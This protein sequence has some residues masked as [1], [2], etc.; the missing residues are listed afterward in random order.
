MR[1][2]RRHAPDAVELLRLAIDCLPVATREAMLEG[3]RANERVIAGAYVDDRGGVCPML[4]AH[5]HGQRTGFVA[6]ARS[7]D[8]FTRAG[9]AREATPRERRILV[10]QLEDSLAACDGLELDVAITEHH[11]LRGRT[12]R[13]QSRRRRDAARRSRDSGSRPDDA[14]DPPGEIRA[15]R[16][17]PW[18]RRARPAGRQ[19]ASL[20]SESPGRRN[21]ISGT[22]HAGEILSR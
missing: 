3:V 13:A 9:S 6:F 10:A 7:W 12:L 1:K 15:R 4:A 17:G 20:Y 16:L 19:A 21:M 14:H 2:R 18:R 8:R 22:T 5:R 11:A